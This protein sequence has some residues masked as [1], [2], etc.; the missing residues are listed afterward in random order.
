MLPAAAAGTSLPSVSSGHRPGPDVLYA[1]AP[2]APQLENTGPWS[3]NPILVSGA[4]S[5]R[6]GEFLYQDFLYDDRGAHGAED[7][8]DPFGRFEFLFAPRWGT[9]TYP[10]DPVFGDNA[11]DLVE[12][13][14]KPL[15]G[16]T[17]FR[18]TVNTLKDPARTAFTI[19]LG[20]SPVARDWP[21]AAGVR[22]PAAL[23][24]TAHGTSARLV[25]AATG[26]PRTPAPQVSVDRTRRQFE[27][28]VPHAAWNP[29]RQRVRMA[30]GVG[31]WDVSAG[32]YLTPQ[33]SATETRP[34]GASASGAALFNLAFRRDEK[35]P[36]F[37]SPLTNTFAEG[38]AHRKADGAYWRER[39]QGD[40]LASGDVSRF[41]ADVD[42]GKLADRA[43]DDAG[44]P[45]TGPIDR[46]YASR[47]VFGQGVDYD[48]DCGGLGETRS[49]CVPRFI[50]QL[51]NYA[52]YVPRKPRPSRGYGLTFL[53][54]GLTGS[55]HDFMASRNQSQFGERGAG[56]V[57]AS[58]FG[59]GPDGFYRDVAEAVVFEVWA[60]VARRYR[61]DPGWTS[62]GGYSM[63]GMGTFRLLARYPDLF[64]RGAPIVGY[65][66]DADPQLPSLRH[67][68]VIAWND[69]EDEL[70]NP[71]LFEPTIARLTELR[72]RFVS[73][74]FHPAG[75]ITIG[76]N[77]QFAPMAQFLGRHRVV[78]SPAHVTY[79]VAPGGDS[80]PRELVADHAYWL[81]GLRVRD[82]KASPTATIDAR[83]AAFGVG[84]PP[85]GELER[86]AGV[87][88]GGAHGALPYV[89]R[90]RSWGRAPR[91]PARNALDVT[92]QNVGR[93]TV[94]GRRAR[95]EGGQPLT[96]HVESDGGG[97]MRLN[98]ALPRGATVERTDG[99]RAARA[100]A[101]APE[102]DLDRR[103][104]TFRLANGSRTYVI[105]P[106]E[107]RGGGDSDDGRGG[108]TD[109]GTGGTAGGDQAGG[110]P[111]AGTAGT[112]GG[113][114]PFTGFAVGIVAALGLL[115]TLAG[116]ALRRR[117]TRDRQYDP[118]TR[119]GATD[120]RA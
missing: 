52:L 22:S 12:L 47:F 60:D 1:P 48:N 10:A 101:A 3:A 57:V 41:A 90:S 43:H 34:G 23:F 92:L 98:L 103:G 67:T 33:A 68:P 42:F 87:L 55:H 94:A 65:A 83:S 19:A 64:A 112:A 100:A 56:S 38:G 18:V 108:E 85:V 97:R 28:R 9:L 81:S 79:V 119:G 93:A 69:G 89:R 116:R 84:D 77:D 71:A 117:T 80:P 39:Y 102:V 4:T 15:A 37:A 14:V 58:P 51:H 35:L 82:A 17:A 5:Y 76:S 104:A 114:L 49:P 78:R 95:L 2:R 72:L 75:H 74:V 115:M 30:A 62:L 63:G 109:D 25:D 107:D 26:V 7:P 99:K 54:H 32:R 86:G 8:N 21:H 29:G 61:L 16:A 111:S 6:E 27:V 13:R 118:A 106:A 20:S 53:L 59:R 36:E 11:A 110:G 40:A 88:T 105:R 31:L 73:D 120:D 24:L 44:V 66:S 70:V 50:G 96:V 113:S 91:R 45:K 46:V